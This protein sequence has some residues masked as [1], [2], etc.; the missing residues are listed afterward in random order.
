MIITPFIFSILI[1]AGLIF[2]ILSFMKIAGAES[3][4]EEML[5]MIDLLYPDVEKEIQEFVLEAYVLKCRYHVL[6]DGGKIEKANSVARQHNQLLDRKK[7]LWLRARD[8]RPNTIE[9]L[10]EDDI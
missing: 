10:P 7:D 6:L 3:R 5:N 1:T 9:Y 2:I 8:I 4:K